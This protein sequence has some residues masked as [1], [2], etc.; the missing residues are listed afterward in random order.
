MVNPFVGAFRLAMIVIT[1]VALWEGAGWGV[2]VVM[3][4]LYLLLVRFLR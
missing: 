3:A 1:L 2:I 4:V